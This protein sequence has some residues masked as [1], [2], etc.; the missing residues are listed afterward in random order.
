VLEVIS[1]T[2]LTFVE[3]NG[4]IEILGVGRHMIIRLNIDRFFLRACGT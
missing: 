2:E 3:A 1:E 4:P